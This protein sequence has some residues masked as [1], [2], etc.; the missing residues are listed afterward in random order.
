MENLEVVEKIDL[1]ENK[2]EKKELD[3]QSILE[4]AGKFH[5]TFDF[6]ETF[7]PLKDYK[8]EELYKVDS[9][10]YIFPIKEEENLI[11]LQHILVI[12]DK[13]VVKH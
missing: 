4:L 6:I 12:N 8:R 11:S 5:V 2:Q 13:F 7:S 3:R 1:T 10:E 9:I